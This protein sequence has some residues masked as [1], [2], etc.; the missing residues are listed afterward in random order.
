MQAGEFDSVQRSGR[1]VARVDQVALIDAAHADDSYV[2][3]GASPAWGR[4]QLVDMRRRFPS[5]EATLP[6]LDDADT[7]TT[8]WTAALRTTD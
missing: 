6:D 2:V 8:F 5:L 1:L 3:D 4:G 7:D